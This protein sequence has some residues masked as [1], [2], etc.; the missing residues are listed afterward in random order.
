[1]SEHNETIAEIVAEM[2]YSIALYANRI[3]AA[4]KRERAEIEA[5]ALAVGG[6]V[7]A[8]RNKPSGDAAAM[9]EE[10]EMMSALFAKGVICTSF[11]NTP[12]EMDLIE[13]L[14]SK[15]TAALNKPLRN[16]DLYG[17]DYK[18]LH[19]AWFDWTGSPSGQNPDGTAKMAFGEWLLAMTAKKGGKA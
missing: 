9:R 14:Y 3:E 6:V 17:G 15:V 18:M 5:N 19:T 1:M 13:E 7:E 4:W 2:R 16:C 8:A 11:A 10:L 12:E